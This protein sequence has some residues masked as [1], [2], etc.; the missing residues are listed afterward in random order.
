[1][2]ILIT[3]DDPISQRIVEGILKKRDYEVIIASNGK[4][5]WEKFTSENI[6]LAIV[7][8]MMPEIDGL[9]LCR[10]IRD[11]ERTKGIGEHCYIIILTGKV[12]TGSVVEGLDAG[13][14]DF[15]TKPFDAN[16]LLARIRSGERTVAL[17][18]RLNEKNKELEK[19]V[20]Q[21]EE[22]LIEVKKLKDLLP[23]CSYCKK[24]RDDQ[25]YWS[26]VEEYIG[27]HSEAKFSHSIC[28]DCFEKY[29]KPEL[30]SFNHEKEG[31]KG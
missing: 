14:D 4:E 11:Y 22:A 5:A 19:T 18:Q 29:V 28:P 23:I 26:E 10:R 27:K 13:A 17:K 25:D 3:E 31:V 20:R 24:I 16:V 6:P 30:E 12:T 21:L 1:M 9:E 15:M 8:W 7:D 2:K